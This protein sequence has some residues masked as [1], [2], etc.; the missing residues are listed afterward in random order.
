MLP[1]IIIAA[2]AVAAAL[3]VFFVN[4]QRRKRV[5]DQVMVVQAGEIANA[6]RRQPADQEGLH[7]SAVSAAVE[8]KATCI[9]TVDTG[10][11]WIED[12]GKS[13]SIE[14]TVLIVDDQPMLRMMLREVLE[15][16]GIN[17]SE[18]ASGHEALELAG[19]NQFDLL[20][21]DMRMP[22]MDGIELLRQLRQWNGNPNANVPCAFI[23]A[24]GDPDKEREAQ[25]LGVTVFIAKPFDIFTV[26]DYVTR[27]LMIAHQLIAE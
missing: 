21:L 25:A 17:V 15:S 24:L 2:A 22:G 11:G 14:R 10:Q 5:I 6:V 9:A 8:E 23:S 19:R 16:S 27:E 1:I 4:R 3:F 13:N 7:F 20:L 18:A 26:R 12:S